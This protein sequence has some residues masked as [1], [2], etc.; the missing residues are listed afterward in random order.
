MVTEHGQNW[1]PCAGPCSSEMF[2]ALV[3]GVL[4]I[5]RVLPSV[6][7]GG[8]P[9]IARDSVSSVTQWS[10]LIPVNTV[11]PDLVKSANDP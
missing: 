10:W 4:R 11:V 7:D 5:S 1:S 3:P 6:A 2:R 8:W 9:L